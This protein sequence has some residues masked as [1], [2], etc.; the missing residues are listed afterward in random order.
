[1]KD[2]VTRLLDRSDEHHNAN[3]GVVTTDIKLFDE[4]AERIGSMAFGINRLLTFIDE[5]TYPVATTEAEELVQKKLRQIL[6][7]MESYGLSESP[8]GKAPR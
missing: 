4:A 8:E 2:L 1:M 7:F 6:D 3:F 5:I